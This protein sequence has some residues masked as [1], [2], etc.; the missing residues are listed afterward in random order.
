MNWTVEKITRH[1]QL[2][3]HLP[4]IPDI[5]PTRVHPAFVVFFP[6]TPTLRDGEWQNHL[7]HPYPTVSP[8]IFA[9]TWVIDLIIQN[10]SINATSAYHITVKLPSISLRFTSMPRLISCIA[11][12]S[13]IL[14]NSCRY[15]DRTWNAYIKN[16]RKRCNWEATL[17]LAGEA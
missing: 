15:S 1:S 2:Y 8:E 4:W 16:N 9:I 11:E 7:L 17:Y 5:L 10:Q 13:D 14:S 3:S 12:S 6:A